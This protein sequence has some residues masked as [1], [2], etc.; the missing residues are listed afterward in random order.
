VTPE[1]R[2]DKLLG[3][4]ARLVVVLEKLVGVMDPKQSLP[5]PRKP[6]H[7]PPKPA[8]SIPNCPKCQKTMRLRTNRNDG[9]Q[10]WGC[11]S[12][13]DC[14]GIVNIQLKRVEPDDDIPY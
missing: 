8:G 13:P 1:E 10:F 6:S 11:S 9:I 12:Y 4:L 3:D 2:S 14:N 7:A 5:P